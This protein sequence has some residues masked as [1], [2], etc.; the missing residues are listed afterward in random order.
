MARE[1]YTLLDVQLGNYFYFEEIV[2]EVPGDVVT[3]WVRRVA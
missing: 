3:F 1:I 2:F